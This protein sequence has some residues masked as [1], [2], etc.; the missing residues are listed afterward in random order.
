MVV[1]IATIAKL[2]THGD[3]ADVRSRLRL[4]TTSQ[5]LNTRKK[6]KPLA[7]MMLW[8]PS[9]MIRDFGQNYGDFSVAKETRPVVY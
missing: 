5:M 1:V 8:R 4:G 6:F 9:R 3:V 2:P 7:V